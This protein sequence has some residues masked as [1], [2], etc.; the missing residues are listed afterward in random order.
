MERYSQS[1]YRHHGKT[2]GRGVNGSSNPDAAVEAISRRFTAPW[3]PKGAARVGSRHVS[4]AEWA[5][6]ACGKAQGLEGLGSSSL[7]LARR[8]TCPGFVF[9]AVEAWAN[10]W[11]CEVRWCR[12]ER[13][14]THEDNYDNLGYRPDDITRDA[15]S[16]TTSECCAATPAR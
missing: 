10:R 8:P 2:A 4:R 13:T 11:G 15:R 7:L 5:D 3:P 12:G 14:V 1:L 6:P 16:S 9:N